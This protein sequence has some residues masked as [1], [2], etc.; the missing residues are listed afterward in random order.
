MKWLNVQVHRPMTRGMRG[1][2]DDE[3]EALNRLW[4]DNDGRSSFGRRAWRVESFLGCLF[5][6][7]RSTGN[8]RTY[9]SHK[10]YEQIHLKLGVALGII[11]SHSSP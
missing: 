10:S 2:H 11:S 7:V 6:R 9:T 8:S 5:V 3:S 1:I 4:G